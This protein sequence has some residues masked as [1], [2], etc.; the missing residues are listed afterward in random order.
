MRTTIDLPEDV[1]AVAASIAQDRRQSL[2]R[3]IVEL[4]RRDWSPRSSASVSIDEATGWS[5]SAGRR[6][7]TSED[8][9]RVDDE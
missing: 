6:P 5:I 2:S 8:V 1:H 3:T 7:I 4:V 9:R